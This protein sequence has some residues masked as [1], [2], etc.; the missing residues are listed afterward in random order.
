MYLNFVKVV[1]VSLFM[2]VFIPTVVYAEPNAVSELT[3]E[4]PK[5]DEQAYLEYIHSLENPVLSSE[6]ELK[7]FQIIDGQKYSPEELKGDDASGI[8]YGGV[9]ATELTGYI[10]FAANVPEYIHEEVYVDIINLNT[11]KIYGCKLYEANGYSAQICVPAGIYMI[12]EGGLTADVGARFYAKGQQF[13]VKR[14]ST[15]TL[16]VDIVDTEPDLAEKAYSETAQEPSSKII[17]TSA[18]AYK[19]KPEGQDEPFDNH[20]RNNIEQSKLPEDKTMPW[21]IT[22]LLTALF[23]GVPIGILIIYSKKYKK[24]KR[25]FYD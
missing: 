14:A 13:Q 3:T 17:S 12:N 18:D 1:I 24:R 22:V 8:I 7:G 25:G 2:N 6:E 19:I 10:T 23:T 4:V 16:V 21:H 9:P 5:E 15:R 20:N 11:Y